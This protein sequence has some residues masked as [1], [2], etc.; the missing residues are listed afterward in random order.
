VR[1]ASPLVHRQ[2][3]DFVQHTIQVVDGN[4][5]AAIAPGQLLREGLVGAGSQL[6]RLDLHII[7]AVETD[8][9]DGL[10]RE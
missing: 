5:I 10:A 8:T 2:G 7:V 3:V 1:S 9:Q 6:L 4:L